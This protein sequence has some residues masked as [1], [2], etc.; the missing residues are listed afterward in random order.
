MVCYSFTY[1]SEGSLFI[2]LLLK[3]SED[4]WIDHAL[5]SG[6]DVWL[7]GSKNDKIVTIE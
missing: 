4:S 1:V 7:A 5:L 2:D 3:V 6:H